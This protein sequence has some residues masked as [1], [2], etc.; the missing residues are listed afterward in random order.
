[1]MNLSMQSM[2]RFMRIC[3]D[4]RG[5]RFPWSWALPLGHLLTLDQ[6]VC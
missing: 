1:M 6:G 2:L 5:I 4:L 3:E